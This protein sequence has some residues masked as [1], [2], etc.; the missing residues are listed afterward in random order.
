M[1]LLPILQLLNLRTIHVIT[2]ILL[3][4]V[5]GMIMAAATAVRD[6]VAVV[7]EILE[8]IPGV[9][10]IVVQEVQGVVLEEDNNEI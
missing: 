4:M 9:V 8:V 5:I 2:T 3:A 10:A 7:H 6:L 1:C